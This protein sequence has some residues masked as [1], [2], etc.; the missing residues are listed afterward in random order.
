M[1]DGRLEIDI[2]GKRFELSKQIID[3]IVRSDCEASGV[4]TNNTKTDK[5]FLERNAEIFVSILM[6]YQGRS[7]HVPP[8]CCPAEFEEELI[9]WGVDRKHVSKCCNGRLNAFSGDQ[10]VL[11]ILERNQKYKESVINVLKELTTEKCS[12]KCLQA[13]GWL[14]L[15]EPTSSLIAKVST[16]CLR[17]MILYFHI[18]HTAFK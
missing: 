12:L 1:E 9:F 13:K 14:I 7:L 15:D 16:L 3:R 5:I 10:Q 18:Y 11:K 6:F 4:F 8:G 2:N 17:L